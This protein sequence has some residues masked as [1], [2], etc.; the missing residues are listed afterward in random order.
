MLIPV[1]GSCPTYLNPEQDTVKRWILGELGKAGME[2]RSVGQTDYPSKAPIREVYTLSKHC[3][4]GIIL[5]FSQLVAS[6]VVRRKGTVI[7]EE[8]GG[9]H[10]FPTPWNQLEAGILYA[11]QK[12]LLVFKEKGIMGGIFDEGVSELFLH[13]LPMVSLSKQKRREMRESIRRFSAEVHEH[14]YRL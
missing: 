13:E 8:V 7:E 4:G 2:W 12:P 11:H 6:Q 9:N 5:G 3:A 14:Y 1:F 10:M